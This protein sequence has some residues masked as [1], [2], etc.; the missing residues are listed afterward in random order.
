MANDTRSTN[1]RKSF[2]C[3]VVD[4]GRRCELIVGSDVLAARL[5]DESAGGLAVAVDRLAGLEVDQTAELHT[6]AGRFSVRV[7]NI[8]EIAPTEDADDGA[9][10]QQHRSFRLGLSRLGETSLPDPSKVSLLAGRLRFRPWQRHSSNGMPLL[11]GGLLP[12]AVVAVPVGLVCL[13]WF[14]GQSTTSWLSQWGNP[15]ATSTEPSRGRWLPSLSQPLANDSPFSESPARSW[16][17]DSASD[18]RTPAFSPDDRHGRKTSRLTPLSGQELADMIRRLLGADPLILSEVVEYLQLTAEQQERIGRVIAASTEAIRNLNTQTPGEQRKK[19]A[20]QREQL[21]HQ[22]RREAI[23]VLTDEQRARWN[24][25]IGQPERPP[26][27][28]RGSTPGNDGE[29]S[30]L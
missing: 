29:A 23:E 8:V 19:I 6:D 27:D 9:D 10:K 21:R 22:A 20:K 25:L 30:P 1:Q 7:A 11:T 14:A 16:K 13:L 28:G 24:K 26:I 17:T 12:I 15:A 2:R 5:L 18:D 3:K 4:T